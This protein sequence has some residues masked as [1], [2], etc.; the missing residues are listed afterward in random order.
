M[1]DPFSALQK[2][3]QTGFHLEAMRNGKYTYAAVQEL[4]DA[5][6]CYNSDNKSSFINLLRALKEAM[7][8]IEKWRVHFNDIKNAMDALAKIH[9]VP[10]IDWNIVLSHPKVSPRF[11]FSAMN[12]S[13]KEDDLLVWLTAKIG[14]PYAQ[15]D[16]GDLTQA[17][18]DNRDRHGFSRKLSKF[19]K[20]EPEFL[21]QL[22]MKSEKN[23]IKITNTRL[24][25][26]LTDEQIA[27]AIVHHTPKLIHK[28]K[29]PIEQVELLINKIN[30]ILSN[31]RS[32]STLLR[33]AEAR[34]ILEQSIFFQIYQ[35]DEYKNRNDQEQQSPPTLS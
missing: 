9:K 23:F 29:E 5:I 2:S 32:V 18:V 22:I 31:G 25:L 11:Q 19:L 28:Q 33:N 12:H 4:K 13:K 10:A 24:I 17:M 14:K 35:S 3:L 1:D 30:A 6:D 21:F 20:T 34:P 15:L 16:H 27:K 8:Y 26:Y 7:P